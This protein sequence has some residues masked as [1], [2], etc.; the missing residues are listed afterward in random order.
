MWQKIGR[1][2]QEADQS[3]EIFWGLFVSFFLLFLREQDTHIFIVQKKM[4]KAPT[5]LK[6]M[7]YRMQSYTRPGIM[8]E[9]RLLF[10]E[11]RQ[12]EWVKEREMM[13][14][15]TQKEKMHETKNTHDP[16]PLSSAHP[17]MEGIWAVGQGAEEDHAHLWWWPWGSSQCREWLLCNS[18]NPQNCV[19]VSMRIVMLL[20][21]LCGKHR[22]RNDE[23][24]TQD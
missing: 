11:T 21:V 1:K 18:S 12:E 24:R 9:E 6:G 4:S 16:Q 8:A 10:L 15:Y 19:S 2:P 13:L 5:Q 3:E 7:I 23:I 14:S 20:K 22:Y 17:M